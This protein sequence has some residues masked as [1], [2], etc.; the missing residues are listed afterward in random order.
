MS[1]LNYNQETWP[2]EHYWHNE[3]KSWA[4]VPL[5]YMEN[6]MVSQAEQDGNI[7]LETQF[8]NPHHE[9]VI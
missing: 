9:K 1:G 6:R 4:E 3:T 5:Q 7:N 8:E 2:Y